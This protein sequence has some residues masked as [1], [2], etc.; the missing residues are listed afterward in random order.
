MQESTMTKTCRKCL[1]ELPSYK[2]HTKLDAADGKHP[3]C[4]DCRRALKGSCERKVMQLGPR[5]VT[6]TY[7]TLI[8][9]LFE[10]ERRQPKNLRVKSIAKRIRDDPSWR[11]NEPTVNLLYDLWERR[12]KHDHDW[13]RIRNL[14]PTEDERTERNRKKLNDSLDWYEELI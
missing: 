7:E 3:Y 2:F 5:E 14:Y 13:D 4:K 8:E 10:L 11:H 6:V 1:Q 9:D 12:M